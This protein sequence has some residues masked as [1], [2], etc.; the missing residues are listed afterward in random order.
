MRYLSLKQIQE[1]NFL[2]AFR[3]ELA[4]RQRDFVSHPIRNL[5]QAYVYREQCVP[6]GI[7]Y[8][9]EM[10]GYVMVIYD[11]DEETYNIWHMMIDKAC[12]GK[13]YGAQA[14]RQVLD[15][16]RTKPFGASDR[17]LLTCSPEN[18]VAWKL[19][20][21]LGFAETGRGDEDEVELGLTLDP[22]DHP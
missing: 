11:H 2:D 14:L 8:G 10:V 15:F 3:Q 7:Y 12:Q 21:S 13:G 6:F 1:S 18:R 17:V 4:E 5:A 22:A 19:Y 16:I 20:R 9:D